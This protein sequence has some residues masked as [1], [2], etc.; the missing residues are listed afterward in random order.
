VSGTTVR[1]SD[2]AGQANPPEPV[3]LLTPPCT[4]SWVIA[5]ML[6]QHP[7]T[8]ALP[9]LH[10]F[11]TETVG[12]WLQ[13]CRTESFEMDHGLVRAVAEL[14]YGEQTE[15]AVLEARGWLQRRAHMTT[16]LLLEHLSER[17]APRVLLERSPSHVYSQ[18]ILQRILEMFPNGR[19]VHLTGHPRSYGETVMTALTERGSPGPGSP[20]DWLA[21]LACFPAEPPTTSV[22]VPDPQWAWLTLHRNIVSF[23]ES[24]PD[25]HKRRIKAED[26]L[27]VNEPCLTSFVDWLGLR[28]DASAIEAMRHPERSPYARPGPASAP[29]GSDV[30]MFGGT[31]YPADWRI[32]KTLD[33]GVNWRTDG[34]GLLPSVKE[35]AGELGYR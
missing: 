11:R 8:Y 6:G 4:F 13:L 2:L 34:A 5:A 30:F 17:V 31:D 19:F 9:E 16:G 20:S 22:G 21:Q 23:L 25:A 18:S 26:V 3:F 12:E 15:D 14:C 28:T 35:L 32:P 29:L 33:G 24:V 10:L 27:E 7:D 1:G